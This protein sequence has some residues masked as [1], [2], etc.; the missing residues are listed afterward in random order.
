L[1]FG[2]R[3]GRKPISFHAAYNWNDQALAMTNRLISVHAGLH[4]VQH[5]AHDLQLFRRVAT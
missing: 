2:K 1:S 4:G 3:S 5:D